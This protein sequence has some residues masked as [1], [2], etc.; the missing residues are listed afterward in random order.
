MARTTITASKKIVSSNKAKAAALP[1]GSLIVGKMARTI[2]SDTVAGV[3]RGDEFKVLQLGQ[4]RGIPVVMVE[5]PNGKKLTLAQS[6][7]VLNP[8]LAAV[9]PAAVAAKVKNAESSTPVKPIAAA[10]RF[11]TVYKTHK[12][13]PAV[14]VGDKMQVIGSTSGGNMLITLSKAGFKGTMPRE[15]FHDPKKGAYVENTGEKKAPRVIKAKPAPIIGKLYTAAQLVDKQVRV[16]FIDKSGMPEEIERAQAHMGKTG[17]ALYPFARPGL[18]FDLLL[19]EFGKKDF[20]LLLPNELAL[21][22]DLVPTKAHPKEPK[23]LTFEQV[24]RA[25]DKREEEEDEEEDAIPLSKKEAAALA[26]AAT[27]VK[28]KLPA[29]VVKTIATRKASKVVLAKGESDDPKK[30]AAAVKRPAPRVIKRK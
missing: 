4:M 29:A 28:G 19:V 25:L 15:M 10:P 2:A 23:T 16:T 6:T 7:F 24:E 18:A 30:I 14:K 11:V 20:A 12:A 26:K 9:L 13:F 1:N 27:P 5:R 8:A 17:K 21:A 3:K 22:S